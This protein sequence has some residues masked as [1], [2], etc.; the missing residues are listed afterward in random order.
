MHNWGKSSP[1]KYYLLRIEEQRGKG[2]ENKRKR[3]NNCK[4]NFSFI[5]EQEL[6]CDSAM[7]AGS[8]L[9]HDSLCS[10]PPHR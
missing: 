6:T 4:K 7:T 1:K 2:D 5:Q 10:S 3:K 8:L 9:P